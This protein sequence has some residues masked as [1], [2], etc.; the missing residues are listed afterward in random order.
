ME[1]TLTATQI[2]ARI[3][4]SERTVLRWIAENQLKATQ[5]RRGHYL[6]DSDAITALAS[7]PMSQ[8]IESR[9]IE[10]ERQIR[11]LET[12]V[13]EL[14]RRPAAPPVRTLR[15]TPAP[16]NTGAVS[17]EKGLPSARSFAEAHGIT[18]WRMEGQIKARAFET[19]GVVVNSAGRVVQS[20]NQEQQA[21]VIAHWDAIGLEYT[22]CADCP[23]IAKTV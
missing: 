5:I 15:P 16:Y 17:T 20:L 13:G 19:T 4:V 1:E 21:A 18:R 8:A 12:R 10:L 6:V 3:G 7:V 9:L 2:A 22:R 23:H 14:E 11:A